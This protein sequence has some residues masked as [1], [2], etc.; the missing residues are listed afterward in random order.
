[1]E[2]KQMQTVIEAAKNIYMKEQKNILT[3]CL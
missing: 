2:E 3:N 1:M